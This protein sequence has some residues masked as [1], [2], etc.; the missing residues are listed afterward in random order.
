MIRSTI[1]REA[2]GLLAL[3][4]LIL[5]SAGP[6]AAVSEAERQEL[7]R[8]QV[9]AS[10]GDSNGNGQIDEEDLAAFLLR[11]RD[12]LVTPWAANLSGSGLVTPEQAEELERSLQLRIASGELQNL[13]E[14]EAIRI[15]SVSSGGSVGDLGVV[16]KEDLAH[17]ERQVV[18]PFGAQLSALLPEAPPP[19]PPEK[20][21]LDRTAEWI[22]IRRSFLDSQG[23]ARPATFSLSHFGTDDATRPPGSD[24]T[25]FRVQGALLFRPE[26]TA[27][28]SDSLFPGYNLDFQPLVSL[29]A[30]ASSDAKPGEGSIVTRL[31][32]TLVL[33]RSSD[34]EDTRAM[35]NDR[36][37]TCALGDFIEAPSGHN[38]DAT[39]NY[40]TDADFE[41]SLYGATLQWSP[42][43]FGVGIGRS[44]I[45]SEHFALR[46]RPYVGLDWAYVSDPGDNPKLATFKNYTNVFARTAVELR[47][48]ER[49]WITPELKYTQETQN[50]GDGH[51]LFSLGARLSLDEKDRLSL[52]ASYRRGEDGPDF[53]ERDSF[54]IGLG[55]KF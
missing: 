41:S 38:L 34:T 14:E 31:G 40:A 12:Q 13:F 33:F 47:I 24:D 25:V 52:E 46:W 51:W 30:D 49:F 4:S 23:V 43:N 35:A 54:Q 6:A 42:N 45:L 26:R 10:I 5:L 28:Q 36:S 8:A 20:S 55:L 22:R 9:L 16:R 48:A 2:G 32:A 1:G 37:G 50:D 53:I 15:V 27:K 44:C 7:R 19:P 3:L 39:A 21:L 17:F 18:S 11:E 29:E